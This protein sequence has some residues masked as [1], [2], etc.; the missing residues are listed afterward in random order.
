MGP[1]VRLAA[2]GDL[3]IRPHLDRGPA[4]V[5]AGENLGFEAG[6]ARRRRQGRRRHELRRPQERRA[7][8]ERD[9]RLRIALLDSGERRR[10]A[11]RLAVV[12]PEQDPLRVAE[13][14]DDRDLR[15]LARERQQAVVLQQH[16]R[17]ARE[18]QRERAVRGAVQLR[19]RRRRCR[20]ATRGIEEPQLEARAQH[21]R[22]GG[23]HLRLREQALLHRIRVLL[24]LRRTLPT[25]VDR[26]VAVRARVDGQGRGLGRRLRIVVPGLDVAHGVAVAGDEAL[27]APLP[28][29]RLA[30][31]ELAGAAGN[32]VH[33]V[34]DA[35][36]RAHLADDD[37]LAEGRQVGVLDVVRG[38]RR[39]EAVAQRLGTAVDRV[40]LGG[41]GRVQVLAVA[42]LQPADE[43]D[44]ELA[45]EERILAVGLLAAA[46]ARIAE[47][48][49]VRREEGQ[50]QEQPTALA[51]LHGLVVLDPRLAADRLGHLV[52]G[53]RV[54]GRAQADRL[55]KDRRDPVV[56]DPVQRLRPQVVLGD[57]RRGIARVPLTSCEAF[58]SGVMR[59]T[60]SSTRR[61]SGCCGSR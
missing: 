49:D 44:T 16:H 60:R 36:H 25:E 35:H 6:L 45:G 42:R 38:G 12:V 46:P 23:V 13:R 21:A 18:A 8:L 37:R 48:V 10:R 9:L 19:V 7:G 2:I 22:E 4:Q 33:G 57:A 29:Q 27:E 32:A 26:A 3:R 14:A 55:R 20:H 43:G 58:S 31:Q 61:S 30:E 51:G 5:R 11:G 28:P 17:L 54:E 52:D 50:A 53:G 40:V 39:V 59:P 47:D 56:R 15:R 41:G 34:V 24:E 1:G